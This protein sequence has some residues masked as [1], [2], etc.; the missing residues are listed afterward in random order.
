MNVIERQPNAQKSSTS[1]I[2]WT[3]DISAELEELKKQINNSLRIFPDYSNLILSRYH[4]AK[5][6]SGIPI[7]TSENT[8][9]VFEEDGF[10][11]IDSHLESVDG[12][13][14]FVMDYMINGASVMKHDLT[15]DNYK[16]QED[17]ANCSLYVKAGDY[18]HLKFSPR[19][20]TPTNP[21]NIHWISYT[22]KLFGLR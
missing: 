1:S 6:S 17:H 9:L 15:P 19:K 7:P 13:N 21:N 4:G 3:K 18:F 2:I 5:D 14:G 20:G 12:Y 10:L 22:L 16:F 8:H 11:I